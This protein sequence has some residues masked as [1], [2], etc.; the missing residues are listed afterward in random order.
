MPLVMKWCHPD[1]TRQVAPLVADSARVNT[2]TRLNPPS[3]NP[4]CHIA[5]T[6]ELIMK[7]ETVLVLECPRNK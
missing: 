7:F 2:T 4:S 1:E 5:V 3:G 6:Y